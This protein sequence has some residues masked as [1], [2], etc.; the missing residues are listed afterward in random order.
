MGEAHVDHTI[1]ALIPEIF[2]PWDEHLNLG[3]DEDFDDLEDLSEV[4]EL[5][6]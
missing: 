1:L 4:T 3:V 5:E 6:F 2:A